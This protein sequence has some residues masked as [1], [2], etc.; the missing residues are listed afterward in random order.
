MTEL[1]RGPK[2]R[3]KLDPS[4]LPFRSRLTGAKRF[5]AW[6][7]KYL[8][9]PKGRGVG[10]PLILR[11]WQVDLVGSVLDSEPRPNIAG[12]MLPRGSGKTSLMAAWAV[13][14]L[15]NGP[16]GNQIVVTAVDQRQ[17]EL[18]F[19]TA[20]A[21]VT[22]NEDLSSRCLVFRERLEVPGNGS[23][24]VAYPAEAKR[25]EGLG[26]FTLAIADEI[27]VIARETWETLLLGL[28]KVDNATVVGIGTPSSDADSV[29][30]NLR[31]YGQENPQDKSFVWREYSAAGFE[32]HAVDCDHCWRISNPALGDFVTEKD[33]RALLPPKTREAEFRRKKLC[34]FPPENDDPFVP[35]EVW[36]AIGTGSGVPEGSEVVIALD[37]SFGGS[38]ADTTALLVGTVDKAPHF[39]TLAVWESDGR[40]D[41]QVDV[42]AVEDEIRQACSRYRVRE[43]VCD[44]FRW[45]RTMQVLAEEGITVSKFSHSTS[46]LTAATTDLYN[47]IVNAQLSHSADETLTRHVMA[48]TVVES[49]KGLKLAK[50][51][52]SRS[53]AK[54]DLAACLVMAHSRCTWY[55]TSRRRS[56]YAGFRR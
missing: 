6:C 34:Q 10:K 7:K 52:R 48:A 42:L 22:A 16:R 47:A 14:E 33:M 35:P 21:M 15:F 40:P 12:W 53:A 56:R 54:I 36:D 9:V 37:G 27:G 3:S 51:S 11:D 39:D 49:D 2:V 4:A 50:V 13:Y 30:L 44:P 43:L 1:A 31:Q 45:T 19:S 17:A 28:G 25:L 20:A 23:T 5:A 26:N 24:F 8:I 29:L 46:R 55:A 32:D 18:A 41:W 38:H